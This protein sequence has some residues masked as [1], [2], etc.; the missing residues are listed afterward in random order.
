MKLLFL[1][2]RKFWWRFIAIA[3]LLPVL[4]FSALVLYIHVKQDTIIQSEIAILNK[5][6]KGL[7]TVGDT[8]LS[9][10][11]NFPDISFKV[12][13]VHIYE[14]KEQNAPVILD[15]ADIYVGFD[16]WDIVNGDYS[17]RSLLIEEGF[18]NI[19]IHEDRTINFQ[20]ALKSFE[21]KESEEF[22]NIQLKNIKLR[23]LDIHKRDETTHTDLETFIYQGKGGFNIDNDL[24]AAHIDT[25]FEMNLIDH[26]DTTYIRHK[27]F[28]L[29]TDVTL[30]Q[31]TGMLT[32]KPSGVEMEHGDFELEGSIDTKNL[33]LIHI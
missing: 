17:I 23:N 18:F 33:S 13:D 29:H 19:V 30:D 27:H 11:G 10:F 32:I 20:N 12:D 22:A 3:I 1:K 5:Q 4:L 2:K 26:G 21:E 9:L 7:I 6:H 16:I 31:H 15:V 24:V 8:H 28:E 25:K 14:T